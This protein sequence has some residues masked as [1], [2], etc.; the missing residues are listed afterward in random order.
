MRSEVFPGDLLSYG[1]NSLSFDAHI[2]IDSDKRFVGWSSEL[3][4]LP[5]APHTMGIVVSNIPSSADLSFK[6]QVLYIVQPLAVGWDVP[7][8]RWRRVPT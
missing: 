2:K 1:A 8:A 7:G 3:R 5:I 4:W 6:E